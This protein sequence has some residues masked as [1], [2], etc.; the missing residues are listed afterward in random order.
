MRFIQKQ[1][2]PPGFFEEWIK[3]Q[4]DTGVNL[5]FKL[6]PNPQK[7]ELVRV[8]VSEQFGLCGYTGKRIK[9]D[10]K[11][12][13]IE[14]LIPQSKCRDDLVAQG[15]V[16]GRDLCCDLDYY[17]MIAAFTTEGRDQFGACKRGNWFGPGFIK[18]TNMIDVE[19]LAY[20]EDGRVIAKNI[21]DTH[22]A[23]F[24]K[25]LN[26][27][28]L[29]QERESKIKALVP[30]EI[31]PPLSEDDIKNIIAYCDT[32]VSGLLPEYCFA[33]KAVAENLISVSP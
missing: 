14:H 19:R 30:T 29:N 8:L 16:L 18:P 7:A 4:Q 25:A 6:F 24:I 21:S 17:N 1:S 31:E 9:V 32:P 5:R 27:D 22:T 11:T 12:T 33:I 3:E 28:Y 26:L 13:H 23:D 20:T 10:P 2:P 15:G